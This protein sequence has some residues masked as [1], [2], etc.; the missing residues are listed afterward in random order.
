MLGIDF[1][2]G[3]YQTNSERIMLLNSL[4]QTEMSLY[5]NRYLFKSQIENRW[6]EMTATYFVQDNV[7]FRFPADTI[8]WPGNHA[9]LHVPSPQR[10]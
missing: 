10:P 4:Y 1:L 2:C 5:S 9:H 7:I 3:S 6:A 8:G